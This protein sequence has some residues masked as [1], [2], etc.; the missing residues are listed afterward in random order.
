M[1]LNDNCVLHCVCLSLLL[2]VALLLVKVP[3]GFEKLPEDLSY[4]TGGRFVYLCV[5]R[6]TS[7]P[8]SEV[9]VVTSSTAEHDDTAQKLKVRQTQMLCHMCLCVLQFHMPIFQY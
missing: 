6:G 1:L 7:S 9:A 5:K 8:V 3:E 4:G 2:R